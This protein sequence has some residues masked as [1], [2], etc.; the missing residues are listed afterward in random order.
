[1]NTYDVDVTFTVIANDQEHAWRKVNAIGEVLKIG[2]KMF[3]LH[4]DEPRLVEDTE[5]SE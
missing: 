1:M 5:P 3:I 2:G 4:I